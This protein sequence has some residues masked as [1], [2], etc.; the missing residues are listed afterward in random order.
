MKS[1]Y[2]K[3]A[4]YGG[5]IECARTDNAFFPLSEVC[6]GTVSLNT[7]TVR[8]METVI[9]TDNINML[10]SYSTSMSVKLTDLFPCLGA[11]GH[12]RLLAV[13]WPNWQNVNS[14]RTSNRISP[15]LP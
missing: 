11:L 6:D 14:D 12:C 8:I 3:L 10:Y 5:E 15:G 13:G 2:P 1:I 7:N 4:L 9:H